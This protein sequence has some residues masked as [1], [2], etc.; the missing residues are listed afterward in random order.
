MNNHGQF[1]HSRRRL[2]SG[3]AVAIGGM[4]LGIRAWPWPDA[5]SEVSHTAEAIH[6]EPVFKASRKHVYDAL[7]ISEQFQ[8]V[9]DIS[10]AV[11]AMS[12]GTKAAEIS[13]EAGGP[14]VLFGGYISGRQ[15]E[16]VPNQRIVQAWRVGSWN[17]GIF[18]IARFELVEQG[19]A[20]KLVFDH[21]GFPIGDG[22]HL[23]EGWA[24]NYWQPLAKFL[25]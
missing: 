8:K 18:S 24:R 25:A 16:L 13:R 4:N 19:D 12:L 7:T 23:A 15:I 2:L 14:F 20:T 9:I 11:Q 1:L 10:G 21:T 17:E 6:Q 22:Q 5:G 3:A